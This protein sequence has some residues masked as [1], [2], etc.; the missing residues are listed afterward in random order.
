[1]NRKILNKLDEKMKKVWKE[2]DKL[3]YIKA[4]VLEFTEGVM[5]GMT[6]NGIVVVGFLMVLK[7]KGYKIN[8]TK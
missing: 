8:I 2:D 4:G 1:M 7:A 3:R 6:I 5:D